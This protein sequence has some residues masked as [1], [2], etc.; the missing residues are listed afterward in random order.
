MAKKITVYTVLIVLTVL[1]LIANVFSLSTAIWKFSVGSEN[2]VQ[3]SSLVA[4]DGE[5][6]N[7]IENCFNIPEDAERK[8]MFF[9]LCTV[10]DKAT[11]SVESGG[12]NVLVEIYSV[13]IYKSYYSA[14]EKY[15][16]NW[17]LCRLENG[18]EVFDYCKVY[19][20]GVVELRK[21]EGNTDIYVIIHGG[22]AKEI[23]S[24]LKK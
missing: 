23:I 6:E 5:R 20:D 4:I 10:G 15:T 9:G 19:E 8:K 22:D 2:P 3:M 24:K 12:K 7:L 1:L 17:D 14:E 11:F 21:I 13:D 18:K 16:V